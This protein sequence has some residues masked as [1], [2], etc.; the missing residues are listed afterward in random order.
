MHATAPLGRCVLC[1]ASIDASND[2]DEHIVPNAIGGRRKL[3]GILCIKCNGTAGHSWDAELAASLN[4]LSLLFDIVRQRGEVPA[5]TFDTTGGYQLRLNAD[6]TVQLAKP[7][8]EVVENGDQAELKIQARSRSEARQLLD[9]LKRTYPKIDVEQM[10]NNVVERS[11]YREHPIKFSLV[12]GGPSAGRSVVKSALCL[13]AAGGI[14]PQVC[15]D[16]RSYLHNDGAHPCFGYYYQR[17][18][19]RNRPVGV[20]LHCVTV[21]SIGTDSQLL[22]YVE[23]F[24]VQRMVVRLA[25]HYAGKPVHSVYS[26]D[27]VSGKELDL[28]VD[29]SLTREDIAATY[30]Y[31]RWPDGSAEV[32]FHGVLRTAFKIALDRE[33]TRVASSATAYALKNC[34]AVEGEVLTEEHLAK[35]SAL[36]AEKMLPLILHLRRHRERNANERG[37]DPVS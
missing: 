15:A 28:D 23:Y 16:A 20:P 34:G 24:G 10:L 14:D 11:E 27:P 32:A 26:I 12:F 18:L 3:P 7:T 29:L 5:Q 13:A 17:D 36:A 1:L 25:D 19:V 33:L 6:G 8:Y 35:F 9:G 21:S 22:A 30:R 2:S 31:E 4:P 37:T